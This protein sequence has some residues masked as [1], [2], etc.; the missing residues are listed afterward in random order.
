MMDKETL[1]IKHFEGTLSTEEAK[2]FDQFIKE[3][4]EFEKEV[5]FQTDVQLALKKEEESEIKSLF[6]K[7]EEEYTNPKKTSKKF[8]VAKIWIA[9][10][11]IAILI[12]CGV[13]FALQN[14]TIAGED[15]YAS[16]FQPYQ[17]V[18]HPLIR[19]IQEKD[20]KTLA[21]EAYERGQY[22]VASELFDKLYQ[23]HQEPYYLFYKANALMKLNRIQEAI[24]LLEKHLTTDDS[25]KEKSVWYLALSHL[26][27]K[28]YPQSKSYLKE[29]IQDKKYNYKKAKELLK[30]LNNL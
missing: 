3:D 2:L 8:G 17:N 22:D 19:G 5:Y 21:F 6:E 29:I 4:P 20:Q 26:K 28:N 18:V 12:G 1:I 13:W 16:Y 25:L 24:P 7:L 14:S 27:T 15:L 30:G 23:K 10:A 11:S 9:A